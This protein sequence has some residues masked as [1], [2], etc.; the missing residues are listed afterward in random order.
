MILAGLSTVGAT[1]LE[2]LSPRPLVRPPEL[3][4]GVVVTPNHGALPHTVGTFEIVRTLEGGA[5][6]SLGLRGKLDEGGRVRLVPGYPGCRTCLENDL[7]L[8]LYDD[9]FIP[10]DVPF[11]WH[12]LVASSLAVY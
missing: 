12:L 11:L 7:E 2:P 4:L 5:A 8:D 6:T 1:A 9:L 10:F 3:T